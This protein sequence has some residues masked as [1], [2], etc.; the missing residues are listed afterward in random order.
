M[1]RI[2][3]GSVSDFRARLQEW[4]ETA[5][6]PLPCATRSHHRTGGTVEQTSPMNDADLARLR[7][8]IPFAVTL[9]I[10][11]LEASPDLVRSRLE[12]APE[13]TTATA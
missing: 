13:L 8:L 3:P 4:G 5:A 1:S 11:L 6:R 12:W 9:G 10:E 7:A 2:V